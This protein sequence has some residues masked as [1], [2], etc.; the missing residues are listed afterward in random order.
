GLP[1]EDFQD[2]TDVLLGVDAPANSSTSFPGGYNVGDIL[3]GLEID[4][5]AN[6]GPGLGGL[7]ILPTGFDGNTSTE[8]GSN[9]FTDNTIINLS[10]A[11]DAIGFDIAC[12]YGSPQVDIAVYDGSGA[13]I[14]G[15]NHVPCDP[16]GFFLG[17]S[18]T[19]PDGIG[20]VELNDPSGVSA[21]TIDNVA[22]GD[23]A[24]GGARAYVRSTVGAPWGS[25]SNEEAMD[26]A[27]GP[28]GWDDL[29]YETVDPGV[30]FSPAYDFLYMEGSDS[31]ADE[32]GAFLAANQAAMEAW[33]A[34]G[35]GLFLNAAP[36]EG[37][38]QA[39]GF[40]GVVLNYPDFSTNPGT[41]FDPVHPIWNGPFLPT[42]LSFTGSSFA[43]ATVSGPGLVPL[44]IDS[45]ARVHLAEL[46]AFGSGSVIFGGLT[47]SNFWTPAPESLNLRANIISYLT[48]P[49]ESCVFCDGF[50]SGDTTLWSNTVGYLPPNYDVDD[51]PNWGDNPPVYSCLEACALLFGGIPGDYQC[52]T[53]SVVIDNLANASTWGIAGCQIVA[54][55]YSLDQGGGYNCGSTGCS[56]SAYVDDN[57]TGGT[58]YCWPQ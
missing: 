13:L 14:W 32:L 10:P 19:A 20:R 40:G 30:L 56:T 6:S 49:G 44:I 26:L 33:V 48:G 17:W 39:W 21:E 1:I 15:G 55:D 52:S 45:V 9:F 27:F 24:G 58:N 2:F 57:C 35:G 42:A 28:G 41:A 34:A 7:L 8:F 12:H 36:N 37:G 43:H 22:F 50:E 5:G 23:A 46:P 53:S 3:P 29:R 31:N 11:V 51:G 47:T 25:T 16:T 4:C 38:S 18:S 54:E